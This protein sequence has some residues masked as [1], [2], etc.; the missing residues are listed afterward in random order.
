MEG[1]SDITRLKI[2]FYRKGA[3]S[4]GSQISHILQTHKISLL[5]NGREISV[6][7]HDGIASR[8]NGIYTLNIKNGLKANAKYTIRAVLSSH[9]GSQGIVKLEIKY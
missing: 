1:A 7:Q 4:N 5:E 2:G 6:D 3:R 8:D 9:R